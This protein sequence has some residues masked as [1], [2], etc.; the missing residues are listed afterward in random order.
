MFHQWNIY[1]MR[2]GGNRKSFPGHPCTSIAVLSW[3]RQTQSP[4]RSTILT[5]CETGRIGSLSEL[6]RSPLTYPRVCKGD[7]PPLRPVV[8]Q[9]GFFYWDLI[10]AEIDIILI[11]CCGRLSS[12]RSTIIEGIIIPIPAF[13]PPSMEKIC[14]SCFG[15]FLMYLVHGFW[16]YL[17]GEILLKVHEL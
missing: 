10:I 3:V 9:R 6:S 7:L 2:Q 5:R 13:Y 4:S 12:Q 15:D 8:A 16:L 11:G 14:C 1:W 17:D